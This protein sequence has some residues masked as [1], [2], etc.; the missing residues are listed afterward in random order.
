MGRAWGASQPKQ[1]GATASHPRAFPQVSG[2]MARNGKPR[3]TTI[4]KS[5][6]QAGGHGGRNLCPQAPAQS[7]R[8]GD[9]S[10]NGEPDSILCAGED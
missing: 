2:T 9:G 10:A 8:P 4:P 6:V 1:S 7:R 3:K 5:G